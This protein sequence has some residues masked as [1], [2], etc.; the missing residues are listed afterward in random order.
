MSQINHRPTEARL[1][2]K[3]GKSSREPQIIPLPKRR[4]GSKA[5]GETLRK[6]YESIVDEPIP[7]RL[8]KMIEALRDAERKE[9]EDD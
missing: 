1:A 9:Q 7:E 2:E 3:P 6:K 4:T 8:Q 5:V